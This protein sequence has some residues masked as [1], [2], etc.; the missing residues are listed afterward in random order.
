ME[1]AQKGLSHIL[2]I[3]INY[4]IVEVKSKRITRPISKNCVC[5]DMKEWIDKYMTIKLKHMI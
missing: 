3:I 1:H 5:I 2:F 4:F